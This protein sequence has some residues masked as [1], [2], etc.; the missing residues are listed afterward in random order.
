MMGSASGRIAT[1]I[2]YL[3]LAGTATVRAQLTQD[4]VLMVVN[5]A[6]AD[7]LAIRDAYLAK[8]PG[9]R[10]FSRA[11]PTDASITREQFED[12]IR[13]PLDQ[14]LRSIPAGESDYLYKAIRALVTTKGVPRR[15][16]DIDD[17]GEP[18]IG[19]SVTTTTPE[20]SAYRYDPA[21]V[22]SELVL[23]HQAL[24]AGDDPLPDNYAN[25]YVRNPYYCSTSRIGTYSRDN[26][27]RD[28]TFRFEGYGWSQSTA[29]VSK[30]FRPGDM[31]LVTRL[32]GYTAAE[33][34]AALNRGGQMPLDKHGWC[35]VLDRNSRNLDG[36]SEEGDFAHARDLLQDDGFN[37]DYDSSSTFVT[38]ASH[39]VI[40][41]SGYGVNHYPDRPP[42]PYHMY[43]LDSLAMTLPPGAIFNT[44]ESW[45]GRD[46]ECTDCHD[47]GLHDAHGQLADWIHIGGTLGFG[48]VFEPY[49]HTVA[50]NEILLERML[51]QRWTF[52]E[53]AYASLY[54]I[55]WQNVVVGDPLATFE[56]MPEVVQWRIVAQHGTLGP[57][58]TPIDDGYVEPRA[59]G[60][61]TLTAEFSH[62]VDP[63]SVTVGVVTV[64][65]QQ[66]GDQSSLIQ[67]VVLDPGRRQL[68]VSLSA[69]LPDADTYVVTITPALKEAGGSSF[70]GNVDLEL[71]TLVGD[72]D[73]SGEVSASDILS[74]R[75]AAGQTPAES[76][77]RFDVDQSGQITGTDILAV[78]SN[79]ARTLP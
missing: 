75:Q 44:Y 37:V 45:N 59:G 77:A 25:N 28:K 43:V 57:V 40:A 14:Y 66:S 52:A 8:Y 24:T 70:G 23:V 6:S 33:A 73:G 20:Y 1:G 56:L 50:D 34:I 26:A 55:S 54:A 35:V 4:N 62:D 67:S 65:G 61:R 71:S 3:L 10:V 22:D 78:R 5:E 48:H 12:K 53:A 49:A 58:T 68:T 11:M 39:P 15:V 47:P 9:V 79:L 42:V 29:Q 17:T 41:Y 31:Y 13:Q 16:Y 64:A 2:L 69:A 38:T 63:T 7:S 74:A 32:T 36:D 76:T 21:C 51:I 18:H 30:Q 46:F 72:A 19:D 60:V 27:T